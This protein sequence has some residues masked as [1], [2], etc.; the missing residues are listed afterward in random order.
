MG[1]GKIVQYAQVEQSNP[2]QKIGVF[3][4]LQFKTP[5]LSLLTEF[6]GKG[7]NLGI[8]VPLLNSTHINIGY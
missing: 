1:T 3:W 2:Q 4:G 6:D 8:H 7:L 5:L